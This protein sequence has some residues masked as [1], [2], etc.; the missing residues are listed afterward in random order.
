MR[1]VETLT[2]DEAIEFSLDCLRQGG[3]T[4]DTGHWQGYETE[5]K[6]D[7]VTKEIINLNFTCQIPPGMVN[8]QVACKPNLPWAE[9]EF[10]ERVGGV[11]RNPHASLAQWPWWRG[12]TEATMYEGMFSHTYSE[13]FWPKDA[14]D[15]SIERVGGS[16]MYGIRYRYGDLDDVIALLRAHPYTRQAT[17]PIFFPED[18]GAVHGGRIPCTLH[19]HFLLRENNLHMWYPIRSCDAVRHFRDDVYMAMRLCQWVIEECQERELR[20]TDPQLW[21]NVKPGVLCF[22]A[23]SFHVHMG[24]YHLLESA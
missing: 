22:T 5:G 13:R 19:Y 3:Q 4:V 14:G 6:P 10:E 20:D 8:A 17:F 16:Q 23:Y 2:A 15:D 9:I 24:D 18:T 12:Q 7:L 1:K 11:P 21:F